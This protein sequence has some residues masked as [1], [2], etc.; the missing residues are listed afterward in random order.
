M[1]CMPAEDK[2]LKI[3]LPGVTDQESVFSSCAEEWDGT[4]RIAELICFN[5]ACPILLNFRSS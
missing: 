2:M 4:K 1:M 3:Q 5:P